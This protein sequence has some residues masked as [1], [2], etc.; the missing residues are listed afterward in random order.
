MDSSKDR[1]DRVRQRIIEKLYSVNV[2][3]YAEMWNSARNV[4]ITAR[5]TGNVRL[6]AP[7]KSF[8]GSL[9]KKLFIKCLNL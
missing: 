4:F 6:L 9:N 7:F 1:S 2:Q 3:V 5:I 8:F